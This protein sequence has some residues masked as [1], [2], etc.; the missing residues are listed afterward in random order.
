MEGTQK[1][2]ELYIYIAVAYGITFLM[3]ILMWYGNSRHLDLS[4]FPNAQM[5]YPAAG[6]MLAF[7]CARRKDTVMPRGFYVFFICITVLLFIMAILSIL[8]P[9][10]V[11]DAG[12]GYILP[13]WSWVMQLSLVGLSIIGWIVLLL[14][15]KEKR[16]AYGLCWGNGAASWFCIVLFVVLYIARSVISLM[17]SGQSAI[18]GDI[19]HNPATWLQVAAVPVNFFFV[20]TAFFGEEYGWRY[21]LQPLLQKRLGLRG[22]VLFL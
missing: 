17:I 15:K 10:A 5:F 3:G 22:G 1:N 21:Y 14:T 4:V 16:R 20:Y 7:L 11:I 12:N 13:L 8:N 18:L 6:V 2:K 9:N 19:V